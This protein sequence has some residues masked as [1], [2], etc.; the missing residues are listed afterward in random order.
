[1]S[2]PS[3]GLTH[4][5]I[6]SSACSRH[7]TCRSVFRTEAAV[8]ETAHLYP[9]IDY[10][11]YNGQI[12]GCVLVKNRTFVFPENHIQTP[13]EI[14]LYRLVVPYGLRKIHDVIN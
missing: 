11:S 13:V 1:M 7:H 14:V 9:V 8:L 12:L 6:K 3:P 4:E 5:R 2:L 10:A